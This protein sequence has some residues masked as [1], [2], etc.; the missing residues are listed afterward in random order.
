[1]GPPGCRACSWTWSGWWW[2]GTRLLSRW[3]W[4]LWGQEQ[5]LD[6]VKITLVVVLFQNLSQDLSVLFRWLS[7]S[8]WWLF[9]QD[10]LLAGIEEAEWTP[11]SWALAVLNIIVGE[12][13]ITSV[14]KYCQASRT[15]FHDSKCKTYIGTSVRR[16][17]FRRILKGR[18]FSGL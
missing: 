12:L 11:E 4:S 7:L 15:S 2:W 9:L 14:N 18:I 8:Y 13:K 16:F 1:M 6:K 3:W 5:K 10:A 17:P